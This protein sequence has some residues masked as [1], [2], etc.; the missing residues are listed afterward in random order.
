MMTTTDQVT[1]HVNEETDIDSDMDDLRDHLSCIPDCETI[2]DSRANI[3]EAIK[4]A[5]SL[6]AA[7]QST[8]ALIDGKR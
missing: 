4:T 3:V 2:A 1:E 5:K 6:I 7:L 8:L